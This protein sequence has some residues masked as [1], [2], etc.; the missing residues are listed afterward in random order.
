MKWKVQSFVTIRQ[1]RVRYCSAP[2]MTRGRVRR[3]ELPLALASEATF[4]SVKIKILL[5]SVQIKILLISVQIKILLMTADTRL[6]THSTENTASNNSY[7]V[8]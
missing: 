5:I 8:G 2:F 6:D 4:I 1:L 3:L 7:I